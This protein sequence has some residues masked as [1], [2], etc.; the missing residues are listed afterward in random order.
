M[1]NKSSHPYATVNILHN[2]INIQCN[3][4]R[5]QA[6]FGTLN[7]AENI[8]KVIFILIIDYLTALF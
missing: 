6:P 8:H 1:F 2:G 3:I 7:Y 5:L 4:P